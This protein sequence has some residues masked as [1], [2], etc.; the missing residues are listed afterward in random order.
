M[1]GFVGYIV[2]NS[3]VAT[4]D[5]IMNLKNMTDIISHRGP[6]DSGYYVD[7]HV[8]FGFRRL[9]I[10]DIEG[11]NQ[12]LSYENER[13]W[14]I[15]NGEIYNYLEL[16][17]E[18]EELG[19]EFK[20]NSDTEVIISLFS[21]KR[22]ES[23]KDLRGMFSFLI[24]D[25]EKKELFGARD[26][27]GIKPFFYLE[28][29]QFLYCSSEMKS[30]TYLKNTIDVNVESLHQY[31]TY[32]FVPE[33]LT[34][35]KEIKKLQPGHYFIKK[36]GKPMDIRA[37]WKP[38]FQPKDLSLNTA[39]IEIQKALRDS[40]NMHMRA[41][42]P[43]GAFLS[44]GI[45]SSAIVALAS[46]VHPN[47][48]TFTV[49]F[50][51]DGFSEIDMATQ[52]AKELNVEHIHYLVKPEDFIKE[53]PK[54]IWHMDEPVADPAAVPLYFVA[55]E[56]SKHVKVVLSGEGADELFGGY[57]IYHEP[58]SLRYITSLPSGIVKGL[59]V[60]SKVIPE[61]IK[62]KS[63]IERGSM[64]LEERYIGN[65][66]IFNEREK[67]SL[68]ADYNELI[69]YQDITKP[70]YKKS[71][72]YH[73][74]HKMQFIDMHTWLRGDILVKADKMT[75]AHSL[76]L[77]VPF[78]DKKVFKVASRLHPNL[79]VTNSTTKYVLR[80]AMKGIVPDS[81]LNRRKLGFP[82]PIR[83]WLK[84]EMA[85]WARELIYTSETNHLLNK[86]VIFKMLEN[87][88]QGKAD[89]SRKLWTVLTFMLWHQIHIEK[90]FHLKEL[91][92][93]E[94]VNL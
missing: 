48:K 35:T 3:S 55:R 29:G 59:N 88:I 87:H 85:E 82:V 22:E 92:L 5:E 4:N 28:D 11:G 42:V 67:R 12:P 71:N 51:R 19:Y 33:P 31:L 7:Q 64:T 76:E 41:D 57:N 49:G 62:G 60:L 15:Y 61:G 46:E 93:S 73:D 16:K 66:K 53:L 69:N 56:A 52:T 47:L 9:S 34:M 43:V 89:Y 81:V 40:V 74:V 36:Q 37:Y 58:H 50:K 91:T 54:I 84:N 26:H 80:E 39:K 8:R 23:L 20:T 6:N 79:T 21:H 78:L 25:K 90:V 70:L 18:L 63:Y 72:D 13:Y 14:I 27:F 44:G 83:H 75:M 17:K 32:Q 45:D 1:C 65:A 30:I 38:S 77:R 10:I 2:N 86:N 24:W 94:G 68:L